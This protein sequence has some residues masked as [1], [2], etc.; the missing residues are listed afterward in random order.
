MNEIFKKYDSDSEY[1]FEEGCWINELWNSSRDADIS[2]ARVRV[3]AGKQ[4]ALHRLNKTTERYVIL[5]G[6]GVVY[7]GERVQENVE[8]NDVVIIPSG[9]KQSIKNTGKSELIFLAICTPR[10]TKSKYKA[11]E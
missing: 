3:K 4:T 1:Y 6:K 2:I 11:L 9:A 7:V 5:Q 8:E 10:F